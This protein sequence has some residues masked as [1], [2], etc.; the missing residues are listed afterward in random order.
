MVEPPRETW[1]TGVGIVSS[2]GE[3]SDA[4]WQHLIEGKPA[5]GTKTIGP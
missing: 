5:D 4:H 3:G 2:L 1:I